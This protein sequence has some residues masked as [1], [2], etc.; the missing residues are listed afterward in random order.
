M[1]DINL[2]IGGNTSQLM[3]DIE[4]TVNRVY[5]IN[6]KTK[7][8]A[9]LGR[10]TGKV[11]E[12]N[13]SLDASNA[14]VI[15]FGASAGIIFGVQRAFSEL[16]RATVEVQKSLQDINVILNVSSSQLQKFG[17]ELFN[18]A[19][20]T[21]QS[22]GAVAE[23]ATE[24]SRQGLG[25]VETLK[26]TSEAL[27]LSRLSG[28]D[29]VKSVEALTAAV[30][31]FASQA[32]T[33][34]EIVNKFA[35]VDAAFAVSS[36]DLAEAIARV[37]SSA[38]QS[39]VSLN[40]LI[41]IVTSA[42]Q[43]TARGGAVIGNSFKT[44]FTRL[45]RGKVVDLLGTLGISDTNA[46]GELKSTIQL[47]Q[48]LG[49]V[50]DTLGARQQA[51]VAEQV[52]GVFQINI[53]KAA[54]ADLGKE[55][56]IYNSALDVAAGSTD[57]AIKRNEELNKTYAA[58][59][60]ALQE[61]ARQAGAAIGGR[62][63]GPAFDRV[64]GNANELLGGLN[65]SDGQGVGSVLGKGILD[66][67]G[68]VLAGP[69]L[70]LIGGVLF[71]LF[72]DLAGFAA[73][74]FQQLLGLNGAAT[75]QKDLQQSINQILQKNPQLL[76]LALKGEQ[77]IANAAALVLQNLRSQTAELQK[78]ATVSAQI[79]KTFYASGVRLSGGVPVV[80]TSKTPKVKSGGFIPNFFAQ[81]E[82]A[83][84]KKS[85]DYTSSQKR[86]AAGDI[87][88]D[89]NFPGL[90]PTVFNGQ[91]SV[92]ASEQVAT[93]M[94]YPAGTKP[95]NP[96]EKY[97][98]LTP[99]MTEN[100]GFAAKGFVPN[101]ATVKDIA[102]FN[103]R[104]KERLSFSQSPRGDGRLQNEDLINLSGRGYKQKEFAIQSGESFKKY[105]SRV[106]QQ[107]Q[108]LLGK[109]YRSGEELR[110]I[111]SA[112]VDGYNISQV[113][114]ET[115]IDLLEVKGGKNW[116]PTS[117][118][119][120]F[121]RAVP[122]NYL[123]GN[124]LDVFKN[125]KD[126]ITLGA[127]L[128]TPFKKEK[129]K[130]TQS[131]LLGRGRYSGFIPNFA[132]ALTETKKEVV[133][134][135]DTRNS[136]LLGGK[137]L[138]LIYPQFSQ[139]YSM[140]Q[141]TGKYLGKT[142]TGKIPV[143]GIDKNRIKGELPDLEKNVD[144]LLLREA[145]QFGQVLGGKNFLQSA[146]DLPNRGAVKG[147]VGVAFEGA[148]KTLIEKSVG[149]SS[150]NVGIDFRTINPQLK[151]LFNEAPGMYDAKRSSALTNEVMQKLLNEV[152]PGAITQKSSG[153]A[154]K[155]Y[156]AQRSAAV[157]Q[158]RKEGVSGSKN[159]KR[160]L[161]NRF[162]IVGKAAG[163][164]PNF[165]A[166]QAPLQKARQ[167]AID[168]ELNAG[169]S[170]GQ[171]RMGASR[172][173][174]TPFNPN[175]D[176]I[177]STKFES[178]LSEG[179][180]MAED[181]GFDPKTKGMSSASG[182]V[183]NF[184]EAAA[185]TQ[186]V[187]GALG[188]QLASILPLLALTAQRG[189]EYAQS[190]QNITEENKKAGKVTNQY[191][192][193]QQKA[194][195]QQ[196]KAG[197][198]TKEQARTQFDKRDAFAPTTGQKIG[199]RFGGGGSAA[200]AAATIAP[201]LAETLKQG[202]D[203]TTKEGRRDA[204]L[205]SG[206]GQ[207]AAFAA[208][209][210]AVGGPVGA[211]VGA[212]AGAGLT[213][214]SVLDEINTDL[215]ELSAAA[216][217][218]SEALTKFNDQSQKIF[219]GAEQVK[220]LREGGQP[221][222][223]AE[224]ETQLLR[225]ISVDFAESP[226]LALKATTAILNK[227]FKSL[228][229]ALNANTQILIKEA[230]EK[231]REESVT[232]SVE[233]LGKEGVGGKVGQEAAKALGLDFFRRVDVTQGPVETGNIENL[234]NLFQQSQRQN[235]FDEADAAAIAAFSDASVFTTS[236]TS[237]VQAPTQEDLI[238]SI[239]ASGLDEASQ[240]V[241]EKLIK[242]Q[243]SVD[244]AIAALEEFKKNIENGNS[245]QESI[246]NNTGKNNKVI[247]LIQAAL[248][249]VA[250]NFNKLAG[251]S[252][253]TLAIQSVFNQAKQE[254]LSAIQV[255]DLSGRAEVAETFGGQ[256]Q[257]RRLGIEAER[258]GI[259]GTF[260]KEVGTA[261]ANV[262]D[263]IGQSLNQGISQGFKEIGSF[264]TGSEEDKAK[265]QLAEAQRLSGAVS[266][267]SILQEVAGI[268]NADQFKQ[269]TGVLDTNAITEAL[270][271]S[272]N[273][274]KLSP[275]DQT[276]TLEQVRQ[277]ISK[278]NQ[279]LQKSLVLQQQQLTILANQKLN[280][281][282]KELAS[283]VINSFGGIEKFITGKA[284]DDTIAD[285]IK[286]ILAERESMRN[287]SRGEIP[288]RDSIT[289][290][291]RRA[292]RL[293]DAFTEVTGGRGGIFTEDTGLVQQ[294][295]RGQANNIEDIFN[296]IRDASMDPNASKSEQ[297]AFEKT[298]QALIEQSGVQPGPGGDMRPVFEEIA[299]IQSLERRKSGEIS[300]GIRDN[301][302]KKLAEIDP[303]LRKLLEFDEKGNL[304]SG[305]A[306]DS[307][308]LSLT[309]ESKQVDL[310]TEIKNILAKTESEVPKAEFEQ[311]AGELQALEDA[312]VAPAAQAGIQLPGTEGITDALYNNIPMLG[313]F[314]TPF[315]FGPTDFTSL[316]DRNASAQALDGG[317]GV[318]GWVEAAQGNLTDQNYYIPAVRAG[319]S[320]ED[321][322]GDG[323]DRGFL[324]K[325]SLNYESFQS[326]SE[327][328]SRQKYTNVPV[329]PI[330][331]TEDIESRLNLAPTAG[332][333][334][335]T[336]NQTFEETTQLRDGILEN[337]S[338][339]RNLSTDLNTLAER[340]AQT[341]VE[342]GS[343]QNLAGGTFGD[344]TVSPAAINVTVEGSLEQDKIAEIERVLREQ[345]DQN[346]TQVIADLQASVSR[347]QETLNN[348]TA[349]N[350][351]VRPPPRG[352]VGAR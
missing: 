173:L 284:L 176:A 195:V 8:E 317:P 39:G 156:V 332:L 269:G 200:F 315:A 232:A 231:S 19:K 49:K 297:E 61:N 103:P 345:S 276:K 326:P 166:I 291:G 128:V 109:S 134:L 330:Y 261:L 220:Q 2:N 280:Q 77:G 288:G 157:E 170:P 331:G 174:E 80:P 144:N 150:Q 167:D 102:K 287:A 91:E 85:P 235:D 86:K 197:T 12:F 140:Q 279:V 114:N 216:Q 113:G 304:I 6:L 168:R 190:L 22:F 258:A 337:V 178:S 305:G 271:Q 243:D 54:L 135:G 159:I 264:G 348:I 314:N 152:K 319:A 148:V 116:N 246:A 229:E 4:K 55:Y 158:L 69:G 318:P 191:A 89:S 124:K 336:S 209:G 346:I 299:K 10:I 129:A 130:P 245:I 221:V 23:A 90:G 230:Q 5:N 58:Q 38:A 306:L 198:L 262:T 290:Y 177:W 223:A 350:P 301:A 289:E 225:D 292:G 222:R 18:I 351:G 68:Q 208:T 16:A 88:Y 46:G 21:G 74:S 212:V 303:N 78:Q 66:G 309:L 51:A 117:V 211:A 325:P 40:E 15:A 203:Q 110:F 142:Y 338:A 186:D 108:S 31:S 26:R 267:E 36:K 257:S 115:S 239:R 81:S 286:E 34:T 84:I 241:L 98:I 27:I 37:G 194:I 217:K 322:F 302:V 294:E 132:Q 214:K 213:L 101:F 265:Q 175:G 234:I 324:N 244:G 334:F 313:D 242:E 247:Q 192:K 70:V 11:N 9:P 75:Q 240:G 118:L 189:D 143:A 145:N 282:I 199:A 163:F 92:V 340:L 210:F 82:L 187:A 275:E 228:T 259:S 274:A 7:G 73:Q 236:A 1:A 182:F 204:A 33:A 308:D 183:P 260:D 249:K 95:K 138:S 29:T 310:L 59:L 35:N 344:I 343:N 14:R 123:S 30:N 327:I 3:R 146:N 335:N 87:R 316:T 255:E 202:I 161:K 71:K 339:V 97:S 250:S 149:Q 273:F 312:I 218:A 133:D 96:A 349:Q 125:Q 127:T 268:L 17:G 25:V 307:A 42:Q 193:E 112:A 277:E 180:A 329:P 205:T 226:D 20:N 323:T 184:A 281:I 188:L 119:N 172:N 215:P 300:T 347:Q 99:A 206:L 298:R 333:G 141:G 272:Q 320:V 28:L 252:S 121:L 237:S 64:V 181:A 278:S 321:L 171:I 154:G 196:R 52:G 136:K 248:S 201:I 147:A 254:A 45:Q 94:G 352:P 227:D 341:N 93:A 83:G 296:A 251:L 122:E 139:G 151:S 50:Y 53:L 32:V 285:D 169:A 43:T 293:L 105:E 207:T 253:E 185:P 13:K 65:E 47:L 153:A 104:V 219:T 76:E 164:I 67:L 120:K 79:A 57:Q 106:L 238:E 41:A 270:Q 311:R 44:I 283:A 72:K 60:N 263:L 131:R 295:I 256:E 155:A 179:I 342:G 62:V 100:L 165:A 160:E 266:P 162:G 48:D 328:M 111:T 56:S 224:I 126:D 63:L 233:T 107:S 24:F 137:V